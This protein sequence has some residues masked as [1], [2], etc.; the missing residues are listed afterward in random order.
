[1]NDNLVLCF[2]LNDMRQDSA[3]DDDAPPKRGARE[4]PRF[5]HG[6]VCLFPSCISSFKWVLL[7]MHVSQDKTQ[8]RVDV[9]RDT[10]N[11][12]CYRTVTVRGAPKSVAHA[13]RLLCQVILKLNCFSFFCL[14]SA[15]R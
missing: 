11:I 7:S 4:Q 12:K 2:H 9:L 1:M 15:S 8:A 3:F 6:S 14:F 10:T 5:H 13:V